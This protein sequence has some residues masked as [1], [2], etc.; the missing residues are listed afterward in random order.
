MAFSGKKRSKTREKSYPSPTNYKTMTIYD[1]YS[2][3]GES[4]Q[5]FNVTAAKKW[6]K[7]HANKGEEVRGT[8]TKVYSTGEWVNCGEITLTGSNRCH[9]VGGS[10][11]S[12][13]Y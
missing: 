4:E 6:M 5:Y 3:S 9:I 7:E 2:N 8:K 11:N 10:K 13:Q 1:V 12:N